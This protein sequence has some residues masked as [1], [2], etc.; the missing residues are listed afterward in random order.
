MRTFGVA[1]GSSQWIDA[2]VGI[3]MVAMKSA[4][5]QAFGVL[6]KIS[7]TAEPQVTSCG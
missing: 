6:T 4:E 7:Q 1:I 5:E 3:V 2:S